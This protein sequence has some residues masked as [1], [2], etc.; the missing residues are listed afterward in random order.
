M[1]EKRILLRDID[2]PDIQDIEVYIENGGYQALQKVFSEMT[3]DEVV[4]EVKDSGLAGRAGAWFP[5]G[6]KWSF[7]PKEPEVPSYL[8]VNADESE[9]GTF[10]DRSLIEGHP[11]Q[12]LEG[13]IIGAYA[14]RARCA[15]IYIRGEFAKGK[16]ML[17]DAISEAYAKGYIGEN[18]LGSGYTLDVYT[19]TGAGAYICGEETALM[20]SLEGKRPN[21]RIKPPFPAQKGV[22]G[23][24]TTVNNIGTLSYVSHI[25]KNGA[26]WFRSIGTEKYPGTYVFCVS[27]HVRKPGLY[28]LEIGS[29]TL[30]EIIDDYAGGIRDGHTLKAVI[31]GGSSTPV[32][33]PEQIDV[34][35]TPEAFAIPGRGEFQGMFG[36]GGIIVMDETTCMVKA[37]FNLLEFYAYESCGQCTPC[38]DAVPW[39]LELVQRIESGEG[40]MKD[41]ELILDFANSVSPLLNGYITVC[42]VGP[43]FAWPTA[44]MVNAFREEFEEHIR[45]GKCVVRN[46]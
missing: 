34:N 27:G 12:S 13:I 3:P 40:T 4:E 32:L 23:N 33:T 42:L 16:R 9:P 46:G 30:R 22:F 44:G 15:Y 21:P 43:S 8:C 38:R 36:T 39:I 2:V 6:V 28:E 35:M 17:D 5:T 24:P 37:L 7:M 25:I 26:D 31:P 11:H 19:H 10:R 29:A 41:L 1:A 20:S 18:I 14:I 45:Q